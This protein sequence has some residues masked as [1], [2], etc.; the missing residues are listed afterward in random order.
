MKKLSL[1]IL[2]ILSAGSVIYAQGFKK[3]VWADEFNYKGLPD[4]SKWAYENGFVRNSEPQYYT[5]GRLENCRVENG[6]LIIEA[7]KEE[8]PNAK[9]KAGSANWAEKDQ[10]AHYTSASLIT[11]GKADWQ[12]GRIEVRAKVPGG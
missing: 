3:L 5:T 10:F 1:F 11:K 8:Y 7:R 9:Y 6:M 4:K 12:Y 2:L